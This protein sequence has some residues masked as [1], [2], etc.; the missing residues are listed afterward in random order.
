MVFDRKAYMKAYNKSYQEINKEKI[1]EYCQT[2]QRKKT[3]RISKWKKYGVISNDYDALYN[4]YINTP[5]CESCN[6]ELTEDKVRTPTTRCLDHSH[7]TGEFRN[8]LCHSCNIK[9]G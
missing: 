3:K 7:T 2:D 1:K 8:V 6:I 4:Q 5:N 9:R